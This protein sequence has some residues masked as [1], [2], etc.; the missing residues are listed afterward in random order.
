MPRN[1]KTI[2]FLLAALN[3][4]HILDFMIMMPLGNY[5]MP[6]F[7]INPKQFTNLVGAYT[8]SAAISGFAAAFFVDRFDRKKVLI[9]AYSG[10]LVGTL[11]CGL[12]PSYHLLLLARLVA[13]LFGG[14]IGAQVL[15]IISDIFPY[16]ERG[17]A[18]GAVMSAF[19]VASTFGVP[20]ALYLANIISWHAPFILV[21]VLGLALVPLL[22]KHIPAI[23]AHI[24]T[25]E[26]ARPMKV[27]T[28]VLANRKQVL[29]LLFSGLIMMG[30]FLIIPFINPFMEFNLG[31][32][33]SQ[34][35]LVYLVG[36]VA[37]F[38]AA[39]ILGRFADKYGKLKVFSIC[40]FL[41]LAMVYILTNLPKW[42]LALVL[43]LFG[44]WFVLATGR[45]VTAQAMV[46]NVVEPAKRG[47]F[48]SFNS[49][50]Q[51]FGTSAA[52]FIAGLLVVNDAE[53]RILHYEWLGYLSIIILL[54]AFVLGRYLF[55]KMEQVPKP[56]AVS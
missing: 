33:K 27:L 21:A 48:M 45:G 22:N 55:G 12:A 5:L 1:T 6:F 10:F 23:T 35:P 29:A 39:N 44:I 37:S 3:F 25:S 32:T 31:Y 28:E 26:E 56:S 18:M 8:L 42:P 52:S 20:F 7:S 54:A 50:L 14:L 41:S 46:S 24:D 13:G 2:L 9:I 53:G 38:F 51:Q 40:I 4:T 11:A 30:H 47:G 16:E 34:T 49:S 19:A 15:S 43:A 36:G 17:K